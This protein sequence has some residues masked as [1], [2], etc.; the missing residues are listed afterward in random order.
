MPEETTITGRLRRNMNGPVLQ[1]IPCP[2][3]EARPW[4]RK[5][6][7]EPRTYH[8][9]FHNFMI[10]QQHAMELHRRYWQ[11]LLDEGWIEV[12]PGMLRHPD[13]PGEEILNG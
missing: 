9:S 8:G 2:E 7:A 4:A 12:A 6:N 13:K 5:L 10:Q 11:K 1:N 3:T